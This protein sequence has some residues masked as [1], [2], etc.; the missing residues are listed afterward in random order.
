MPPTEPKTIEQILTNTPQT[1]KDRATAKLTAKSPKAK[2][3]KQGTLST[4]MRELGK[5]NDVLDKRATTMAESKVIKPTL[6]QKGF[7][8][9]EQARRKFIDSGTTIARI[10]R[11]NADP[12]LYFFY[13]N[14]RNARKRAEFQIGEAQTD[15]TGRIIGKSL[16]EIFKPIQKYAVTYN[17]FQDYMFH[18]HN[19]DRMAFESKAKAEL[20]AFVQK[21]PEF[22]GKSILPSKD[23][24]PNARKIHGT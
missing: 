22:I 16:K 11:M 8:V 6:K 17:R 5:L 20:N 12:V 1:S 15:V 9:T 4:K 7:E 24:S 3:A 14:A 13:N 23:L 19:I 2:I 10:A 18:L 21:H